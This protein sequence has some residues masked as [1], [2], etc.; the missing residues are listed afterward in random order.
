MT[1]FDDLTG[2]QGSNVVQLKSFVHICMRFGSKLIIVPSVGLC[3][4]LVHSREEPAGRPGAE[5][6]AKQKS[7]LVITHCSGKKKRWKSKALSRCPIGRAPQAET[8]SVK[9]SHSRSQ[10]AISPKL[11]CR[12][13]SEDLFLLRFSRTIVRILRSKSTV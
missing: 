9:F 2:T 8:I 1:P 4:V 10:C 6:I 3:L 13:Q 5:S 11:S 12:T 7:N